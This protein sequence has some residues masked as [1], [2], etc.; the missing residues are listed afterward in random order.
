MMVLSL[1]T[2]YVTANTWRID[3]FARLP[4][5]R[6]MAV[7]LG[8][9]SKPMVGHVIFAGSSGVLLY[10][11]ASR[12]VH[13]LRLENVKQIFECRMIE[14]TDKSQHRDACPPADGVA[15]AASTQPAEMAIAGPASRK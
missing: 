3:K 15:P 10:E 7:K 11:Y 13:L 12:Q 6:S 14:P 8:D 5:T 2:G 1:M 9:G 4:L